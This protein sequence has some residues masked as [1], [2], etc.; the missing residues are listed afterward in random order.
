MGFSLA[1]RFRN[2]GSRWPI[3]DVDFWGPICLADFLFFLQVKIYIGCLKTRYFND[4]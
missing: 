4:A 1:E 2:Q 3:Y